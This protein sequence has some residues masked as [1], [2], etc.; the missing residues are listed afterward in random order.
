MYSVPLIQPDLRREEAVHQIVDALFLLETISTD[1]FRRYA[2]RNFANNA[3]HSS[4]RNSVSKRKLRLFF[5]GPR[6]VFIECP[7]VSRKIAAACRASTTE[8][9]WFRLVL[10]GSKAVKKPPR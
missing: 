6:V 1:I 3:H 2:P 7:K 8:S 4:F 5:F 9:D 10:T